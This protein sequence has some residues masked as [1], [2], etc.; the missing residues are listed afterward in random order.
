MGTTGFISIRRLIPGAALTAALA[1]APALHAQTAQDST[2]IFRL[3][4]K[5]TPTTSTAPT[6][7]TTST[8]ATRA[9]A[10]ADSGLFR[11]ARGGSLLEV[12][13]GNLATQR[14]SS[15]T[16]KDFGRRMATDH[17]AMGNRW[18]SLAARNS[19]P[20]PTT[21]TSGQQGQVDRL[22]S[23]SGAEFDREYMSTMVQDHQED[24][25]TLKRMGPSARS[26]EARQLASN[27]LA[28]MQEHLTLAQ[29]I[30]G[31]LG[32]VAVNPGSETGPVANN[33]GKGGKG[34]VRGDEYYVKE[35]SQGHAMEVELAQLAQQKARDPRVKQF[36]QNLLNDFRDYRDRWASLASNAGVSLSGH[37]GPKHQDKV[38]RLK[39]A[40]RGQFDRVYL[41]IVRENLGSMLPYFQKEGRQAQ[42]S[43]VRNLVNRELPTLQQHLNRVE[44]LDRQV[45]AG[46]GKAK[47]RDKSLSSNE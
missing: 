33:G 39:K 47:D 24:I 1:L 26:P 9:Q 20:V 37:L 31:Q 43:Q 34:E 6:T 4:T 22:G 36:A 19:V 40:G 10:L 12:R 46:K 23:L 17:L 27:D 8:S 32:G 38:D 2:R 11:E 18:A 42:S 44:N 45:Q 15:S 41:D 25:A 5:G 35:V 29:Q 30:V 7:P 16:V 13:L 14:A 28:T 21:L 3:P